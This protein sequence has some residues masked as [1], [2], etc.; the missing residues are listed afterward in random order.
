M[1]RGYSET[2]AK[3]SAARIYQKTRKSNEPELNA[4]VARENK[5]KQR[6]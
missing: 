4:A 2:A 1:E 6:G 5:R 3:T